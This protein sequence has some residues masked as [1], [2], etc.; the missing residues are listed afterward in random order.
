MPVSIKSDVMYNRGMALFVNQSG[1][2]SKLQERLAAELAEKNK[3]KTQHLDSTPPD[4][5]EDSNYIKN[6]KATTSLA[7]VWILIVI[8]IVAAAVIYIIVSGNS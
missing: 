6:T 7:W 8:S 2:R 1:N 4:G 3:Q 5:V